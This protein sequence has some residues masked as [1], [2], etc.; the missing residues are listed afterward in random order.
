MQ[1]NVTVEIKKRHT[2][3]LQSLMQEFE[4]HRLPRLLRLKDKVDC[5]EALNEIDLEFLCKEMKD[6]SVTMHLTVIYPEL[7]EFCLSMGHLCKEISDEALENE[8]S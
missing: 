8:M 6:A 1:A 7:Q 2:G 3:I 5:G 4:Q